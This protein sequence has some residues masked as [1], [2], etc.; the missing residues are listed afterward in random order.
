MIRGGERMVGESAHEPGE[1]IVIRLIEGA[2]VAHVVD[3]QL[4][5][6]RVSTGRHAQR[7]A[8]EADL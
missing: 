1:R 4:H 2:L 3:A 6:P 5:L 7:T 8:R